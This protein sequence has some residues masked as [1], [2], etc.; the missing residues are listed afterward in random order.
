MNCGNT[1]RQRAKLTLPAPQ[2][3][4]DISPITSI[5]RLD[6]GLVPLIDFEA[7]TA[8]IGISGKNTWI[9]SSSANDSADRDKI[10]IIFA[11]DSVL[12]SE[13]IKDSLT[14]AG[15]KILRGFGDRDELWQ[16]L[17]D[18]TKTLS[19]DEVKKAIAC[20]V[21]D[22]EMPRMDGLSLTRRIRNTPATA[23]IP[24]IVYSPIAS[25][26]NMKKGQQVGAT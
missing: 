14:D 24:V 26:D 23:N 19:P 12:I 15:F 22:V 8:S 9:G 1:A 4:S 7:I 21:T 11:D 16:Y 20:V 6:S 18:L 10:P 5:W 13:M 3:G 17:D 25:E 2:L